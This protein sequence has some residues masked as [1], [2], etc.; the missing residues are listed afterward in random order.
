M[1][2][3]EKGKFSPFP[4]HIAIITDGNRRWAEQHGLPREEGHRAGVE[5]LRTVIERLVSYDLPYLT[6]FGFSTENWSRSENEVKVLL[7]LLE[8]VLGNETG[9]L[10]KRGIRLRHLG[11][12]EGLPASAQEV[13]RR[14]AELTK[15]NNKMVL[16]FA[17]NY[18]GRGE[19][20]DAVNK[21]IQD[22]VTPAQLN[23]RLF[24]EYL[25]TA[26]MPDV[27]M[28]IRTGGETR[29]SNFLIWQSVYSEIFFSD[30]LW[31]DFNESEIDKALL[32]YSQ[33]QRRFGK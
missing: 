23:E 30:V 2:T 21:L 6:I 12:L 9:G 13:I 29:L 26:G 11:R 33:K 25:Y 5:S 8:E 1:T 16:S 7:M 3:P 15:N 4:S 24:S 17:F 28:V 18:G 19:I 32:F 27:D 31:P 20:M 10:H 22:K 14:S